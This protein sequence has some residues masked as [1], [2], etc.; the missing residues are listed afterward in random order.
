MQVTFDDCPHVQPALDQGLLLLAEPLEVFGHLPVHGL[1]DHGCR[2][3]ANPGHF[4]PA[5]LLMMMAA[6]LLRH[7]RDDACG[8]AIGTHPIGIG[9]RAFQ[10]VSDFPQGLYWI[11]SDRLRRGRGLS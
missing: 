11:H 9:A 5:A 1:G 6:F 3:G 8:T 4:C 7:L 2:L 10:Q